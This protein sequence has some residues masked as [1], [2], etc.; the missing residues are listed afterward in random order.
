MTVNITG[1]FIVLVTRY[2]AIKGAKILWIGYATSLVYG[3]ITL[4]SGYK[5]I[6]GQNGYL[7]QLMLKV[8]PGMDAAWFSGMLA[9]VFVM[10]FA[11]TG[12]HMLF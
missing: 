11:T 7:T 10:T 4:V 2:F 9:V 12:N 5:F 8:F 6:Y 1:I 3:G